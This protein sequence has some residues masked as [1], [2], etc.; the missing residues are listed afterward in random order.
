M[1]EGM[2]GKLIAKTMEKAIM[3]SLKPS[4]AHPAIKSITSRVE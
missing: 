2:G 1:V 3:G 4:E